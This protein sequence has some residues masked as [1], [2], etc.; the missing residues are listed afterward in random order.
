MRIDIGK[1]EAAMIIRGLKKIGEDFTA[2]RFQK[3]L[4]KENGKTKTLPLSNARAHSVG[5]KRGYGTENA[6]QHNG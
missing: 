6:V 1:I 4:D 2:E 5:F 3:M